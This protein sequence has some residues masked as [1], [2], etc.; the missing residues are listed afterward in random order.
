MET[1]EGEGEE[2]IRRVK[3]DQ[4]QTRKKTWAGVSCYQKRWIELIIEAWCRRYS[5]GSRISRWNAIK[6]Y[7]IIYIMN[8]VC[9]CSFPCICV[10]SNMKGETA[11]E[12]RFHCNCTYSVFCCFLKCLTGTQNSTNVIQK[13]LFGLNIDS[14]PF[15]HNILGFL[16]FSWITVQREL[17]RKSPPICS[18]AARYVLSSYGSNFPFYRSAQ[19]S[20]ALVGIQFFFY[21]HTVTL[22]SSHYIG[23]R[24]E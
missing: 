10:I 20:S 15:H 24:S 3:N 22:S 8:G 12:S 7:G 13:N 23:N 21:T 19:W 17:K 11:S 16:D 2:F 4:R 9:W 5:R 18:A 6:R 1:S 14:Y